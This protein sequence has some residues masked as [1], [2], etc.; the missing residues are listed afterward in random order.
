M[1]NLF[2]KILFTSAIL[3]IFSGFFPGQ[4]D[5][6]FEISKNIDVFGK[7]YKEISL[8]Y[9]DEINPEEFMRAG[10]RGMLNSLDPYTIFIDEN[11]KDEIDLIT[12][13]KYGGVGISIGVRGD[14]VTVVEV[15]DGYSAQKQGVRIGDVLIEADGQKISSE[16]VDEISTYVK[17][18]PGTQVE[19]KII[20]NESKDT[21]LFNL[22]REEVLI[23]NITYYGFY[24]PESNN[25]YI[26]LSNFSRSAG[27]EV[28][29]ALKDLKSQKDIKSIIL[30]LRGN[31][32]GLLDVAVDICDKF[33]EK[34]KLIVSTKGRDLA[35]EKKYFSVQEPM[36]G[37]SRIVLLINEGSASASEIVAGAIQ[38]QDRGVILGVKSFGKGLVQ[39]IS[40]LSYNTSLKITTAKYYTPSGRCIQKIDYTQKNK[41][42]A[43]TDSIDNG[44][45]YTPNKRIVYGGG[46]I[47]P[48]STVEF[49]IEGD[50]TKDLLAKGMF[51]K[52]ANSYYEGNASSKLSE[53]KNEKLFASFISF[54][55]KQKY[56]YQSD[57]EKQI[58][59]L[60][61]DVH[62]KKMDT[63]LSDDLKKIR[64]Q[65]ETLDNSEYKIYEDEI[66]REIKIELAA[67]YTG[68]EGKIT[69]SLEGDKQFQAALKIA[70]N[71][72]IYNGILH[73]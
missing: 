55:E 72:K 53:I 9:V 7:V 29:K 39:T 58:D 52:F 31:P 41:V 45:Y 62:K 54:L 64:K 10:I 50:V 23:K 28:K 25:A 56:L 65:F 37:D 14:E 21:L 20:R 17:G 2:K 4:G 6:Y 12:N 22:I 51:F 44:T 35:S 32:G 16:N 67:R 49:K 26:K 61:E 48:D 68:T 70:T 71:E 15:L 30:D 63:S 66:L 40:P 73:N 59:K 46:G 24:P 38:D 8:N 33:L 34:D 5:I 1:N 42:M 69:A 47:T 18:E 43:V 3:I 27:D 19:I 60:I 36:S 11:K 13:G 57:A